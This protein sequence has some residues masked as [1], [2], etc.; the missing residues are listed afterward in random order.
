MT[1]F[2]VIGTRDISIT[3]SGEAWVEADTEAEAKA[4]AE[5]DPDGLDWSWDELD[6]DDG[7]VDSIVIKSVKGESDEPD[8]PEEA[9]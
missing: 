4:L 6:A 5:D 3:Q 2:R 7:D 8:E 9:A 1:E